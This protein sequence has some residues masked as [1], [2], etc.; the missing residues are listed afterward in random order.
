LDGGELWGTVEDYN[1]IGFGD[2]FQ[3]Y[4]QSTFFAGGIRQGR[5]AVR[6]RGIGRQKIDP[7]EAARFDGLG[8]FRLVK[9]YVGERRPGGLASL[10]ELDGRVAGAIAID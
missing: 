9:E 5:G 1:V 2:F 4:P 6:E 3:S 10:Q 7:L 8:G